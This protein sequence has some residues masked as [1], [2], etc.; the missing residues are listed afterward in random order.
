MPAVNRSAIRLPGAAQPAVEL[1]L[2][3]PLGRILAFAVDYL[4]IAAYIAALTGITF[5]LRLTP[6]GEDFIS[7]MNNPPSGQLAVFLMLTLPVALYFAVLEGAPH[8]AT[9]GK[10]VLGL[11]VVAAGDHRLSLRRSLARSA[12]KFLPWEVAHT[13]LWR[14]PGWP[15]AP[16]QPSLVIWTG[17]A[18][19]GLLVVLYLGSLWSRSRQ[20][21][22]DHLAGSYV[23]Q[24]EHVELPARMLD[25]RSRR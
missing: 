6:L 7:L 8:G 13:C 24:N 3:R 16:D 10:R 14:I 18:V 23:V 17:F 5:G 11:R 12:V 15:L 21:P 2:A 4:V 22:Y 1:V 19:V 20:A 25:Q 9:L